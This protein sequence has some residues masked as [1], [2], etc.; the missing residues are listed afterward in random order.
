MIR[1]VNI[2]ERMR[3]VNV[4]SSDSIL[5]GQ[6]KSSVARKITIRISIEHY[7]NAQASKNILTS[8]EDFLFKDIG[9]LL[10]FSM[11]YLLQ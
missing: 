8:M 3:E 4:N 9:D 7:P 5:N 11:S 1:E 10:L 6:A 2:K